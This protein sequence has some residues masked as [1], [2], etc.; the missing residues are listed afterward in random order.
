MGGEFLP[1]DIHPDPLLDHCTF[2]TYN[3]DPLL[4]IHGKKTPLAFMNYL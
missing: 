1:T 3:N 4:S 2:S